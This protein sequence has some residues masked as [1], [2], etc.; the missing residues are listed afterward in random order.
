MNGP[1]YISGPISSKPKT[2]IAD[3]KRAKEWLLYFDYFPIDP[4]DVSPYEEGK[5]WEDY[6]ADCLSYLIRDCDHIYLLPGWLHSKGAWL[7]LIVALFCKIKI[8]NFSLPKDRS[9]G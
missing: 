2:H 8:L 7:E 1:A 6:L 4:H 9:N 3:F 5:Q